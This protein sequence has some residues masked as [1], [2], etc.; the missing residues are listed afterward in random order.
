MSWLIHYDSYLWLIHMTHTY[1]S[2]VMTHAI[3]LILVIHTWKD[4]QHHKDMDVI[5]YY[6]SYIMIHTSWLILMTHMSR[7][8]GYDSYLW[9]LRFDYHMR[10][11]L[12][13]HYDSYHTTI[14]EHKQFFFSELKETNAFLLTKQLISVSD[15]LHG[16]TF[17]WTMIYKMV[18]IQIDDQN[19][20]STGRW[21]QSSITC[22]AKAILCTSSNFFRHN[23]D[24]VLSIS[25]EKTW[26]I[27]SDAT[28]ELRIVLIQ[29]GWV[30]FL[31]LH[32]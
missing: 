10:P 14:T 3:W 19:T 26:N 24:F 18:A 22:T 17:S 16:M 2:Y 27:T 15:R 31:D 29:I 25:T 5:I 1:D 8:T 11:L 6:D 4:G 21:S 30:K 13:T 32:W 28:S 20:M 7:R 23:H 12:A 9:F